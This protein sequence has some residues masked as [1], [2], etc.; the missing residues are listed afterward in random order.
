MIY[1]V[2]SKLLSEGESA[3]WSVALAFTFIMAKQSNT[4]ALDLVPTL[5]TLNE[6]A[7]YEKC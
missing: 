4:N 1:V 5:A 7:Y 2:G 6:C 3:G